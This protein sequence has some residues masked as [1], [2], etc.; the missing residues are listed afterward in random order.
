[1][2]FDSFIPVPL[3]VDLVAAFLRRYPGGVSSVLE[4]VARDFL[5]RTAD[6]FPDTS[7]KDDGVQWES[8]FLPDGTKIRTKYFGKY[9]EA[10]IS[11]GHI[12]WDGETHASMSKLASAMRGGTSNNAWK[13]LEIKR[14]FDATWN[15]ADFLRR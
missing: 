9:E 15:P 4:H 2:N 8:L 1:M 13:V 11:K 12:H 5:D 6:D 10:S 3:P 7:S 14:P